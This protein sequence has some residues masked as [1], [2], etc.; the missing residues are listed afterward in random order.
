MRGE[1]AG[2]ASPEEGAGAA[3]LL[4]APRSVLLDPICLKPCP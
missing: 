3:R 1:G 2:V 4:S